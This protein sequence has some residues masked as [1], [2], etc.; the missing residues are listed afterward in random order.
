M[1]RTRATAWKLNKLVKEEIMVRFEE[2]WEVGE[3]EV[4]IR[5]QLQIRA[6]NNI[7]IRKTL[8]LTLGFFLGKYPLK[9]R[10]ILQPNY[11]YIVY[12]LISPL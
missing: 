12:I 2:V 11:L 9:F 7:F 8:K 4:G 5:S 1:R 6:K 10:Q 3:I